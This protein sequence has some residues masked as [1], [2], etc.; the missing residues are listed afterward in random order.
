M[1]DFKINGGI[2]VTLYSNMITFRDIN[3]SFKLDGDILETIT[4]YDFNVDHSNQQDR[5]LFYEFG[6][7]LTFDIKQKG[8]KSDREKSLI[9]LL[10]SP[11]IM[12]SGI[13]TK[14]LSSDPD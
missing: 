7:E 6:K 1:N 14:V 9:R 2:P 4:N 5:K 11:A 12:A 8:R 10:K 13:S 3:K